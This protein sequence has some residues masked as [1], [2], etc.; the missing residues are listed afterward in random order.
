MYRVVTFYQL[1]MKFKTYDFEVKIVNHVRGEM[2]GRMAYKVMQVSLPVVC[3]R[4]SS[5]ISLLL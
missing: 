1:K 3:K 2:L 4:D 5:V